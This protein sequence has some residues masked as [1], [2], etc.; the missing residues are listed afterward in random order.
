MQDFHNQKEEGQSPDG[1][2]SSFEDESFDFAKQKSELFAK[3]NEM[4]TA[5]DGYKELKTKGE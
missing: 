3:L 4:K 1:M 5:I 2:N